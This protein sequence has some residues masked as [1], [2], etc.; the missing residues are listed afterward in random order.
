MGRAEIIILVSFVLVGAG[1]LALESAGPDAVRI[2]AISACLLLIALMVIGLVMRARI[3][4]RRSLEA[5]RN[6]D[7]ALGR[8][9]DRQG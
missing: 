3:K 6:P 9:G 7:A 4:K 8:P 5:S 2:I 1:A